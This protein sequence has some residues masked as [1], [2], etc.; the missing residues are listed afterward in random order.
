[1]TA[2][3]PTVFRSGL[4]GLCMMIIALLCSSSAAANDDES[5][6]DGLAA[7]DGGDIAETVRIWS[8]LAEAGDVQAHV[9]LAGLYLAGN[10]V[11]RDA[12]EAARLYRLAA[13]RGDSNG[14]LNL[15]RLYL[16]GVGVGRDEALAYAWLSLAAKQGRRWA[17]EKRRDIEPGLSADQKAEAARLIDEIET[18]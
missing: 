14:Q 1:M 9:G 16:T 2:I 4:A 13:E 18:R 10:G 8:A 12:E 3:G 6:F 7:F 5:F 17:D 15:G 11:M